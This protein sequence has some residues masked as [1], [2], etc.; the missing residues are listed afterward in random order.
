[1]N[2]PGIVEFDSFTIKTPRGEVK[3]AP[4]EIEIKQ[5]QNTVERPR[6]RVSWGGVPGELKIGENAVISLSVAGRVQGLTLP[7]P[8]LFVPVVPPGHILEFIPLSAE[9]KRSGTALK[10]RLIPLLTV[11]FTLERRQLLF[12]GA[13]FEIP[14]VRIPVSRQTAAP[15][16][17]DAPVPHTPPEPPAPETANGHA[18]ASPFPSFEAATAN[19]PGLSN[20]DRTE[21]ETVYGTARNLWERGSRADALAL[22]RRNERDHRAGALF[23]AIRREA[24]LSLG[25]TATNGERR[26][27]WPFGNTG[28]RAAVLKETTVRRIPDSAGAEIARFR[29]GQPVLVSRENGQART[30][31]PPAGGT[32]HRESWLRVVTNDGAGISGWV[33]EENIIFY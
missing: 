12:G 21:C 2:S 1:L 27:G 6:Y 9:E 8:R 31:R 26:G 24:E 29:E 28:S 16:R 22:L 18:G 4:F 5:Q 32:G 33:P 15:A 19:H 25:F 23:A 7:E 20:K 17:A 14:A 11:P 30:E 3:T 13:V 10:M